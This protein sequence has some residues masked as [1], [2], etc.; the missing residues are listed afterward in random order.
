MMIIVKYIFKVCLQINYPDIEE[1]ARLSWQPMVKDQLF[2][3]GIARLNGDTIYLKVCKTIDSIF[4]LWVIINIFL[5]MI[6]QV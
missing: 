6:I 4:V 3:Q 2:Q 5:V 1:P